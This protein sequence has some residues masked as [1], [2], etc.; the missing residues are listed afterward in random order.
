MT[1]KEVLKKYQA[2]DETELFLSHLLKCSK[3]D[4]FLDPN[5][6]VN[7]GQISLLEAMI[8][9]LNKGKPAAYILGYKYFYNLKFKVDSSTL[10]PRPE[11][12][13]LVEKALEFINKTPEQKLNVLDIGTG[14]GCL[15]ISIAKHTNPAMVKITASD[16]SRKA[17][18][19]AKTNART[20]KV[21]VNFV[22]SDLLEKLPDN[23]DLIIANLPYVPVT[24]Y[25]KFHTNLKHE[26]ISALTDG[27]DNFI[28]YEKLLEQL[29][30]RQNLP[31]M[32]IFELDP[33][34]KPALEDLLKSYLPQASITFHKDLQG[35]W[36]Y[37][38]LQ[39]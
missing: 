17:L 35:L 14:S 9:Q 10:I 12:E 8:K 15:A 37:A 11:S 34:T 4:L 27:T 24:D 22:Y 5:R 23:Y 21:H 29:K 13:W 33:K 28:L 2:T 39:S 32:V 26:P 31:S 19:I 6:L 16:I 1:I 3:E 20:H 18:E 30:S 7:Q 38:I 36:R 25:N